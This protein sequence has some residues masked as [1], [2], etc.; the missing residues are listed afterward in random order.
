MKRIVHRIAVI[1]IVLS[2]MM[3][4]RAIS[5]F[6]HNGDTVAEV[7][8]EKL[9]RSELNKLIPKGIAAEDSVRLARQY[10][11]S[12]ALDQV[13]LQVAEEQLSKEEKDVSKELEDYR[14]SLLK[15]KYEQ[16]YVNER[17]DTAVS[18]DMVEEYYEANKD[19]FKLHRPIVKARYLRISNDS[20]TLAKIRKKMASDEAR[21]LVEADSLAYSSAL[22]FSAWG[23]N[24][25]DI[26]TLASEF[27]MDHVSLKMSISNSW[28]E[29]V[30]TAGILSLAYIS[31]MVSEGQVAPVEYCAPMIKDMIISARKQALTTSLE[32]DLLNDARQTGQFVITE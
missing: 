10:I 9:Y 29:K 4:C 19:K 26:T 12:W 20:P 6:L 25:I 11:N 21:D 24:W 18:E 23:N 22:K 14:K 5:S 17:L 8:A 13:F 27:P 3:S 15:Y 28:V 32:Q 2:A 30:D 1:V 7:G 31:G 16:L